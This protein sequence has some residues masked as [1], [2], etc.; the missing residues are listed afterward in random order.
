MKYRLPLLT[1][2]A[3]TLTLYT[4]YSILHT[5]TSEV[6]YHAGFLVYVDGVKQD[7]SDFKYMELE[8]CTDHKDAHKEDEQKEKAHLHDGIGD[9]VHVHRAN[10]VW[11]DLFQNIGYTFPANKTIIGYQNGQRIERI[12][13]ILEKP[14]MPN[15][16]LIIAVGDFDIGALRSPV[17]L[18]HIKE[19]ESKSET[20]GVN[21]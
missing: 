9:V 5:P 11:G 16:S 7:F 8:P 1:F 15:D 12:E 17:T 21:Q 13:N 18:D 20:C 2:L 19:V 3:L 10:A 14:I 4:T 6:H